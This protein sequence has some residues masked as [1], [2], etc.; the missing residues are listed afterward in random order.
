MT[1]I[2]PSQWPGLYPDFIH[3]FGLETKVFFILLDSLNRQRLLVGKN[4]LLFLLV[5]NVG[6]GGMIQNDY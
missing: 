5:Q 6:N 1:G 2:D 4:V 3:A